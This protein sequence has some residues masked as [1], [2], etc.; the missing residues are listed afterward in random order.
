VVANVILGLRL[1]GQPAVGVSVQIDGRTSKIQLTKEHCTH[2]LFPLGRSFRWDLISKPPGSN[3]TLGETSTLSPTLPIDRAGRYQVR[4][5]G[6]P[7]GCT[8]DGHSVEADTSDLV[9]NATDEIVIPPE[10]VPVLPPSVLNAVQNE[11]SDNADFKCDGGGGWTDPE[12]VTVNPWNGP[13]DYERLEGWV[14]SCYLG[15]SEDP[16][17][18][19]GKTFGTVWNDVNVVVE[20]DSNHHHLL[21]FG[22][23][24]LPTITAEWE[25][26]EIPEEFRPSAG[27]R[28]SVFGFWVHDCGE[29]PPFYTEIHPPVGIAVHRAR[30]IHIPSEVMLTFRSANCPEPPFCP[31]QRS[32]IGSNVYVPGI[33]TDIFFN[34]RGGEMKNCTRLAALHQPRQPAGEGACISDPSPLNRV[35][36]FNI[37]LPR[38]PRA[39]YRQVG[40]TVP[41]VPLFSHV[42]GGE[43]P[44]PSIRVVKEGDVTYLRVTL[45][46][47]GFEGNV[48]ERRI[49]S[50]WAFPSPNNWQ[51]RAWRLRLNSIEVHDSRDSWPNDGGDWRLWVNTN[52]IDRE[53]DRIID[54]D[55]CIN[56]GTLTQTTVSGGRVDFP[57]ETGGP[58]GPDILTFGDQRIWVH[59]SG[60]EADF[61]GQGE[62]LGDVNDWRP[63]VADPQQEF[64]G[65]VAGEY[66]TRC[67]RSTYT[68]HYQI[69]AGSAPAPPQ[70][71]PA[72]QFLYDSYKLRGTN[73][74][75]AA[76]PVTSP[77]QHP[78]VDMILK[79]GQPPVA[80]ESTPLFKLHPSPEHALPGIK[81]AEFK[82]KLQ[83]TADPAKK[84]KILQVLQDLRHYFD[85]ELRPGAPADGRAQL[86]DRL[87][88]LKDAVP[89]EFYDTYFRELGATLDLSGD[90]DGDGVVDAADLA[91][92]DRAITATEKLS[93]QELRRAGIG[94]KCGDPSPL[95]LKS[96]QA[97]LAKFVEAMAAY[98]AD[99]AKGKKPAPVRINEECHPGKLVGRPSAESQ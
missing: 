5:T 83:I 19:T 7:S 12:W 68:L 75:A 76:L 81:P 51:L 8:V 31:E 16:L 99:I 45:D 3:A 63:P 90:V 42:S 72:A 96:D 37:Y 36:E 29:G 52:N 91:R 97:V 1:I 92:L 84:K 26:F 78:V 88:L 20:P 28:V 4:L 21:F 86:P 18:H 54:C 62:A 25:G 55:D 27:D 17:T 44:T 23:P 60:Y 14:W 56:T 2:S 46:L 66:C 48:Y 30:P 69:L 87:R 73:G 71:S 57:V 39:I 41:P 70:L 79:V 32:S 64:C 94:P 24:T 74:G 53:W 11:T 6:C 82:R 98:D 50:G 38:D 61:E 85:S 47:N 59:A 22:P 93:P 89:K 43:G 40:R 34:P 13:Q 58:L 10:T 95:A 33:V 35:F 65:E 77:V 80:L 15:S 9:V 49:V 67:D